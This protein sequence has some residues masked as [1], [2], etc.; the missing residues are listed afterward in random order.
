MK[1]QE[2]MFIGIDQY[3]TVYRNLHHPRKDL[4]ERFAVKHIDKLYE[5][6]PDGTTRHVGYVICGRWIRL[7]YIK[8]FAKLLIGFPEV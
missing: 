3:G 7:Y 8:P 2:I 1:K 4:C 6:Y 5:D